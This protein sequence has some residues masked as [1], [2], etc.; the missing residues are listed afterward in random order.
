MMMVIEGGKVS[1]AIFEI[2]SNKK[3]L[4]FVAFFDLFSF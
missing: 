1:K 3:I 4:N 2:K